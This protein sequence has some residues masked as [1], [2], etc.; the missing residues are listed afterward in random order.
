MLSTATTTVVNGQTSQPECYNWTQLHLFDPNPN[1][2][3][4]EGDYVESA[5]ASIYANCADD[6][7]VPKK[8]DMG[9]GGS[10]TTGTAYT[11]EC[12]K[13]GG[14]MW[15]YTFHPLCG[16]ITSTNDAVVDGVLVCATASCVDIGVSNLIPQKGL[17]D[18][19]VDDN[20]TC[21]KGTSNLKQVPVPDMNSQPECY[22]WT[23]LH[24]FDTNPN[25]KPAEDAYLDLVADTL[26]SNCIDS[27]TNTT[28][29]CS[30]GLGPSDIGNEYIEECTKYGGK[31]WMYDLKPQC[32]SD[33]PD[34]SLTGV[35]VCASASCVEVGVVNLYPRQEEMYIHFDA[36]GVG[37]G[38]ASSNLRGGYSSGRRQSAE[39][40]VAVVVTMVGLLMV[41]F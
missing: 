37:C 6:N 32:G 22:N 18:P 24:L 14:R 23:Q 26:G 11:N 15:T 1:L 33:Y 7:G 34:M 9:L 17:L 20:Y 21:G 28:K 40:F 10:T 8:C 16:D 27:A 31:I 30:I 4:A 39:Y 36:I 3:P 29:S 41:I 12:T 5:A 2:K 13:N 19:F 25:M 38:S 35:L